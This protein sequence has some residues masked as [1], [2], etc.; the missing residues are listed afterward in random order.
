MDKDFGIYLF[1][2]HYALQNI[3][4]TEQQLKKRTKGGYN[5]TSFSFQVIC[6]LITKK[7]A[8]HNC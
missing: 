4:D 6:T 7:T 8:L 1:I 2:D 3:S 5:N